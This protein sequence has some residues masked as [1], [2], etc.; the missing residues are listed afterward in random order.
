MNKQEKPIEK[1]YLRFRT[2]LGEDRFRID[3]LVSDNDIVTTYRGYDI[4]RKK[5]VLIHELFPKAIT[6]RAAGEEQDI[7]VK[8]YSDEE[9]FNSLKRAMIAR[10]KKMI[11]LY[12]LENAGNILSYLEENGT[13]YCV[14]ETNA[15]AVTLSQFLLKRH[16]AKFT[17]EDLL[18]Y[19]KPV[20]ALLEK[21][22][23]KG[24]WHGSIG[25]DTILITPDRKPILSHLTDPCEKIAN[26]RLQNPSIRRDGFT[27]VE[28][29]VEDATPGPKAD[30][31]AV[32][33]LLYRYTTGEEL[34]PYYERVNDGKE[35]KAPKDAETRIMDFQSDA[36]M[37]ATALYDFDRYDSLMDFLKDL[38]PDDMELE[39]LYSHQE[40]AKTQKKLPFW[41]RREL[42]S[43][44]FY[45]IA[46]IALALIFIVLLIPRAKVIITDQR[47]NHFY[48]KFNQATDYEKCQMLMKL[49]QKDRELFTNDYMDLPDDLTDEERMEMLDI[50]FFDFTLNHYVGVSQVDTKRDQYEYM[51]IDYMLGQGWVTYISND[52]SRREEMSLTPEADGSYR[53]EISETDKT[54]K[55]T[56]ETRMVVPAE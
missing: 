51:K 46:V 13:V 14:E 53:V 55:Q 50:K 56:T 41:Y 48:R 8:L 7:S 35:P 45:L 52:V 31:F 12:P 25:P 54:G 42:Y 24:F 5:D 2:M 22:H 18:Q 47:I 32:G 37:K 1:P 16:S 49:D 6:Q 33:A 28:L 36:I 34:P 19:L 26:E 27:P 44:R 4:F 30:L 3:G 10:A 21:L 29:Y 39:D 17:V 9:I 15:D 23:K 40:E 43:K 20:F 38:A 11:G